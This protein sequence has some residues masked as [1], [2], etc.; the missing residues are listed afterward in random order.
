MR[1]INSRRIRWMG[2]TARIEEIKKYA[3]FWSENLKG[4]DY[5]ENLGIDGRIT[6]EL[7]LEKQGGELWTGFIWLKIGTSGGIL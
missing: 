1:V 6:S 7:I 4:R 2:N 3:K 5:L